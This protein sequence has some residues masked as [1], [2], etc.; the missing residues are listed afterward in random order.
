MALPPVLGFW[1]GSC[2]NNS[3][4]P[5]LAGN[6]DWHRQDRKSSICS[7]LLFGCYRSNEH[8]LIK[9]LGICSQVQTCERCTGWDSASGTLRRFRYLASETWGFQPTAEVVIPAFFPLLHNS[10]AWLCLIL[11]LFLPKGSSC[12]ACSLSS[13][14]QELLVFLSE[15][16]SFISSFLSL[17]GLLLT[18]LLSEKSVKQLPQLSATCWGL[19]KPF[20]ALPEGTR[21]RKSEVTFFSL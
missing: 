16:R 20:P 17:N 7:D 19:D 13:F 8:S 6:V 14:T 1:M 11:Q 9:Q 18:W 15:R 4:L 21:N 2:P 5:A 10:F 12:L 3:Q